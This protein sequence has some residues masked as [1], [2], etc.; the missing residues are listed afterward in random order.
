MLQP[1]LLLR[2]SH[3]SL[4][5]GVALYHKGATKVDISIPVLQV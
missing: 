3:V 4:L 5:S 2:N 1:L